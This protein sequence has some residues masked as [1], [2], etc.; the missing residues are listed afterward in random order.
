MLLNMDI[1]VLN[2]PSVRPL[3][4]TNSFFHIAITYLCHHQVSLCTHM[5]NY[6]EY[7]YSLYLVHHYIPDT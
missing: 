7:V 5:Y 4:Y 2:H 3:L 6:N 1:H